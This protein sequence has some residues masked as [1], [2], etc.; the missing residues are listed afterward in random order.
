MLRLIW[1]FLIIFYSRTINFKTSYVT[2][3]RIDWDK[4]SRKQQN[5]KT[6]YVTVN[7]EPRRIKV[8]HGEKFQ[9]ILCYG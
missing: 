8:K 1:I 3:N 4:L 9:N 7:L 2:V 5:F 6:S